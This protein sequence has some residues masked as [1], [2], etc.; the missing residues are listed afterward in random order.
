[1]YLLIFPT[2]E[3]LPA[4]FYSEKPE[5]MIGYTGPIHAPLSEKSLSFL[6]RFV[7][8]PEN[9]ADPI[10]REPNFT[11]QEIEKMRSFG[12]RGL[13]NLMAEVRRLERPEV[14]Q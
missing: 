3:G 10:G 8:W 4:S 13:G 7:Q 12:P 11:D 6:Y 1:M 9:V 2:T 14:N 5:H